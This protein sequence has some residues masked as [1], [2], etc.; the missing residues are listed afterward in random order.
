[1]YENGRINQICSNISVLTFAGFWTR[2]ATSENTCLSVAE[3]RAHYKQPCVHQN[4]SRRTFTLVT[5]RN[6]S[7]IC[8]DRTPCPQ[9]RKRSSCA[10]YGM[11]APSLL[12]LPP[13]AMLGSRNS[14]VVLVFCKT[15]LDPSNK[16]IILTGAP[17]PLAM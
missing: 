8:L 6:H 7:I 9:T 15:V 5:L 11:N 1:M 2:C 16:Q 13:T 3:K 10:A 4:V 14:I 12:H 17:L